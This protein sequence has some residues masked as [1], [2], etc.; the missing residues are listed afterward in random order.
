[1]L[2]VMKKN[3]LLPVF[4]LSIAIRFCNGQC[5][6]F[7]QAVPN[8]IFPCQGFCNGQ[9]IIDPMWINGTPP[10]AF[11]SNLGTVIP[12]QPHPGWT[13]IINLCGGSNVVVNIS[14]A[15][16]CTGVDNI[17]MIEAPIMNPVITTKSSCISGDS[18]IVVSN[19]PDW[20]WQLKFVLSIVNG[21]EVHEIILNP[22]DTSLVLNF[23]APGNYTL[24][25][26]Y[27]FTDYLS[28]GWFGC[29]Q[30][31]PLTVPSPPHPPA[32][33]TP[34]GPT[35]FC[36]GGSVLLQ[37]PAGANRTYQW[38]KGGNPIA[39][40]ISSSYTAITGGNYRVVVTNTVTG[41]TKETQSATVVT[42]NP[43]PAATIAPQG[44]TTFCAGG[45]VLL[46]G[47]NGTGFTYQWKK[48]GTNIAGAT[49]KN[50]TATVA[51][52]YKLKVTNS[53]GCSKISAGVTVS[54]PCKEGEVI[55][56]ESNFN[57]TVFPNPNSGEFT[58]KFSNKP[59]FPVK[60]E[61]TDE[62]GKV[63]K[64]FESNDE[65]IVIKESGLTKGI[66]CLTAQNN[67]EVVIKKIKIL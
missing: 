44:P 2:T 55:S 41:C 65:T 50:Y 13:T 15:A 36:S 18:S 27:Q 56:T 61:M 35:T 11:T 20:F 52:I 49:L 58:I 54:V 19:L 12:D 37:A 10:Y 7:I 47:N 8:T 30:T 3:L 23:I 46:K 40:A 43:L 4:L 28:Q 25:I 62:I 39:G 60:I 14:D 22:G 59:N 48:N 26:S 63:V 64:R 66:Y 31:F 42:V 67:N 32:T 17:T 1:M 16:G 21:P 51:G 24:E 38:E 9:L 29:P 45:S 53:S 34:G 33:I 6:P 57:F 5:T